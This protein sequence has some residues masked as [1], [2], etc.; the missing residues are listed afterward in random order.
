MNKNKTAVITGATS[1]IGA[2]FARILAQQG[3]DLLIT[4]RRKEKIRAFA[5]ELM[6]K[7]GVT[8]K[9]SIVELSDDS[10]LERLIEEIRALPDVSLLV[11]NAGFGKAGVVS[12][13]LD[14]HLQMLKVHV[15]AAVRLTQSVVGRMI[16]AEQG[17]IINVASV[18]AFFPMPGSVTYSATKR[19]LVTF[20]EAL[21][22]ELMTHGIRMQVLCP[23][24]T[25]T[26][27]H[28]KMG[29]EGQDIENRY[30]LGWMSPDKVAELSLKRLDSRRVVYV[31]GVMNKFLVRIVS[32]MPRCLYYP[33][34]SRMRT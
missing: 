21:H 1:G 14:R 26:D 15:F 16:A 6:A 34:V 3:Y 24:M 33:L 19:F 11:N 4:G 12:G 32:K 18:A 5:E 17:A 27:F 2:A 20:T 30:P 10:Q 31:P 13:D 28:S 29:K 9:V 8:V 7:N 23:G 25:R 22:T